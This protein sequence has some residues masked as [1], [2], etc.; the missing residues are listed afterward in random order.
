MKENYTKNSFFAINILSSTIKGLKNTFG[1]NTSSK[2]IFF[3]FLLFLVQNVIAAQGIGDFKSSGSVGSWTSSSS[4]LIYSSTGY[5]TTT[6]YPGQLTGT[7]NV[8][9]DQNHVISFSASPSPALNAFGTLTIMGRLELIGSNS[10][11]TYAIPTTNIIVTPNL[12]ILYLKDKVKLSLL[13]GTTLEVI[14]NVSVTPQYYGLVSTPLTSQQV[15]SIGGREVI[16]GNGNGSNLSFEDVMKGGGYNT[17]KVDPASASS[18]GPGPFSF[19]AT[20]APKQNATFKWYTSAGS[21][22]TTGVS[23]ISDSSK[24]E[25]SVSITTTFYVEATYSGY[26]TPRKAVTVTVNTAAPPTASAQTFCSVDAKKVSDLF[27]TGTVIKWYNAATAGTQYAGTAILATGTY[28]AS[29]TT[30]GCESARTSVSVAVN[31]SPSA[32]TVDNTTRPDCKELKGSVT[33]SSLPSGGTINQIGTNSISYPITASSMTISGLNPNTYKFTVTTSSGCVSFATNDIVIEPAKTNTWNGTAWSQ[34]IVPTLND[35]VVFTGDYPPAAYPTVDILA[36]SCTVTGS[37]NVVIKSGIT[38]KVVNEV[39]IEGSGTGVGTLTFENN[40]SLVQVNDAAVN[41]GVII[42]KRNTTPISN[43]D[44]TYWSSPVAGQTLFNLSPNTLGDKFYSYDSEI[45]DWK[46][47]NSG[48]TMSLGTGYIVRGPQNHA[49][50]APPGLYEAIFKGAP[51]NGVIKTAIG[52]AESSNLIGNPY[53]S[54]LD[55]DS[56]LTANNSV[57]E[58]T[59]YFWTHN[60]NIGIGVSNPGTGVYAYS[61]DDYAAYNLTGGAAAA[62]SVGPNTS[63]PSGKIASGQSFFTTSIAAGEAVFNNSMRVGVDGINGDNSQFF[64]FKTSH[65]SNIILEKNRVWLNLSNT[66]GAFKQTLVGYITGATNEYENGFDGESYDSNAFLDFYSIYQDKNLVIQGRALPFT[67]TDQVPLGYSS[68]IVGNFEISI[69]Q[70]DGLLVDKD[71]FLEDKLLGTIHNLKNESYSFITEKGVFNDR[72]ILLYA[73]KTLAKEDFELPEKAVFISNTNKEVKVNS[74]SDLIAKV[75]IYDI[76]GKQIYKN[77]KVDSKD[78]VI[79]SMQRADQILLVNVELQNG[80][81]VTQ[82]IIY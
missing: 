80:Q 23:S 10:E 56:F 57:I 74:Y 61:S 65:K 16:S 36:C 68:T 70:S 45:D 52:P 69:G 17:V 22:I 55:A 79:R 35:R 24:Y 54:A 37:K 51:N 21:L 49:A 29:Q 5:V 59:L 63:I 62:P 81:S 27:A 8:L 11:I 34:G 28:Y 64:K 33:L 82:K 44:Y 20:T 71:V 4:W 47:E 25:G 6:Q 60:T 75:L 38:M 31:D 41:T 2:K 67:D 40:A 42:Y 18:C 3:A 77:T 32:P 30:N 46:Q 78:L 48:N 73:N 12:G 26:T 9:I 1:V 50:P 14:N 13:A 72:F 19:T 53:P 39:I 76:S 66:Q 58:G 7:Y 43:F 15:I